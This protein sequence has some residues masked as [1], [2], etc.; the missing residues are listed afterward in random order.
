M[1]V[2]PPN[3]VSFPAGAAEDPLVH[4][5]LPSVGP[6]L[7]SHALEAAK[8]VAPSPQVDLTH[9]FHPSDPDGLDPTKGFDT[10]GLNTPDL[11]P[12]SKGWRPSQIWSDPP[13]AASTSKRSWETSSPP[14][15]VQPTSSQ[16]PHWLQTEEEQQVPTNKLWVVLPGLMLSLFLASLDQSIVS[17]AL[18][19]II[20]ELHA[21]AG[22]Y[23]WTGSA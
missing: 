9:E 4:D 10:P 8:T 19:T 16:A 15:A 14:T 1:A 12:P 2:A 7:T 3:S 23:S 5:D 18:P 21:G 11:E 20:S 6:A 13:I 22:G 17:T